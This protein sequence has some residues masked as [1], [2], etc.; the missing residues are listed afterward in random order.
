MTRVSRLGDTLRTTVRSRV[1]T[2]ADWF[3]DFLR[4]PGR[5]VEFVRYT[6]VSAASLGLDLAVFALLLSAEVMSAALA[7]AVSC[8][9]GLVLH[10]LLSVHFVFDAGA[11]HK[12]QKRLII[13]YG[14]TG[15]MGFVITAAAIWI[16]V[17]GIGLPAGI[18][19]A[20]GIGATFVSVYLVRAGFVFA[21]HRLNATKPDSAPLSMF[22]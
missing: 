5:S 22:R 19:K 21:P 6:G 7:G 2:W 15:V 3:K 18:G 12:S 9:V 20:A 4:T 16:T 17:D 13:E 8:M 1:L 14:L 11:T 10:Y